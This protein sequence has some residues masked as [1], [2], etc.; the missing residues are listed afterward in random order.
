MRG[1]IARLN[2]SAL[3][4]MPTRGSLGKVTGTRRVYTPTYSCVR[5]SRASV[6]VPQKACSLT[7]RG[8]FPRVDRGRNKEALSAVFFN[9][10]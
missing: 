7:A 5:G 1:S 6:G 3:S 8:G 9:A 10:R 4:M 2:F